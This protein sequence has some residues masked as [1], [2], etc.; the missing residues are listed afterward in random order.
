MA[1]TG[2]P[3]S[4]C[5][6]AVA[7][8]V[9]RAPSN[10]TYHTLEELPFRLPTGVNWLFNVQDLKVYC[11]KG[12]DSGTWRMVRF[13]IGQSQFV[14]FSNRWELTTWQI[15]TIYAYRWQIELIFLFLKRTLNGLHLLTHSRN[16]LENQFYC[17][18]SAA[19]L[20]LHFKQ[21]N[22]AATTAAAP[23]AEPVQVPGPSGTA[24]AQPQTRSQTEARP[25]PA[26]APPSPTA[27]KSAEPSCAKS[28][29]AEQEAKLED[30]AAARAAGS[31]E[32]PCD[33]NEPVSSRTAPS[34]NTNSA[35]PTT[36]QGTIEDDHTAKWYR[37]LGK[38]L[39]TFWRI[40]IHWL[41]TLRDNLARVWDPAV[42]ANLPGQA[43]PRK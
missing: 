38:K 1:A 11:D 15:I 36:R 37:D 14:L 2:R 8:F 25:T 28:A 21:R 30:R 42:F 43:K 13:V 27:E 10:V 41:Q 17:L 12:E 24:A 31:P 35:E 3:C 16:G 39:A 40:S 19:L 32:Q 22:D 9:I 20:L 23:A 34:R 26:E 33:K 7:F 18:L 6:A 5:I 29:E 4:A